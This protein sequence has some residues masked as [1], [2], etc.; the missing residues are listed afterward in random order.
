MSASLLPGRRTS[1]G[2]ALGPGGLWAALPG[3]RLW[4]RALGTS[5]LPDGTWQELGEAL[6]ELA[7]QLAP[8]SLVLHVALLPPLGQVRWVQ[9]PPLGD[10][11]L[12]LV[13]ARDA[14]RY[15]PGPA[16]ARAVGVERARRGGG[17][18]PVL[19][20]AAA[21]PLLDAVHSAAAAAGC[22]VASTVP[23]Y[24]AW[25]AAAGAQ[26]PE[27]G[28][29]RGALLVAGE[30]RIEVVHVEEGRLAFL[31]RLPAAGCE[32]ARLLDALGEPPSGG[33]PV[34]V[35]AP[36]P[37]RFLVGAL[38]AAEGV[39][40]AEP[41]AGS[42]FAESPEGLAAAFAPRASGPELLPEREHAG[43]RRREARRTLWLAATAVVLLAATA[44]LELWGARRELEAVRAR[45]RT[46]QASVGEVM[47]V[48]EAIGSLNG[49]LTS[50]AELEG[51]A[52]RWSDVVARVAE[53]LPRDAHL[54][55]FRG[56]A[57]TLVLEGAAGRAGG[58]IAAMQ[59]VPGLSGVRAGAP[60]RRETGERGG[61]VDRFS[62]VARV[63]RSPAGQA[64][65]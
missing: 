11:E 40:A 64:P 42:P 47:E 17:A 65:R 2:V 20:A 6:G 28:R 50:L 21:R 30:D 29:A 49:R 38:L 52:P 3:D 31:R 54:T 23:A 7:A 22:R 12:R 10:D 18:G 14:G 1:V 53:R 32:P 16:E 24:S 57:D 25:A 58:V 41:R 62:L 60:I 59:R 9:L 13:L 39:R 4:T 44:G 45:R 5:A 36:D 51:S 34:A 33:K 26:W 56:R 48:R 35:V 15:F 19:A 27:I 46:I 8:A 61:V 55:A 43:R 37:Q 63:V